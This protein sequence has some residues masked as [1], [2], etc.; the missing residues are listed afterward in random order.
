MK[1]VAIVQ[2]VTS[3]YRES[4]YRLLCEQDEDFTVVLYSDRINPES[5]IK[6]IDP[7]KASLPV[8][9]GGLRWR[10][11]KS[12]CLFGN[13]IWQK[14]VVKLGISKEFDVI[15]YS[16]SAYFL[17]TWISCFLA[18]M[19]GKRTL[20]WCHGF[21]RE[22]EGLKGWI[23]KIFYRLLADGVLL[24]HNRAKRIMIN[25]GFDADSLYVIYNSLDYDTQCKIKDEISHEEI[26]SRRQKMFNRPDLPLWLFIGR[27]NRSKKLEMILDAAKILKDRGC[28]CNILIIGDGPEKNNLK[29]L[30]KKQELD[31]NVFL[32]G[33]TYDEKELSYLISMSDICVSP[34]E[35]GLTCM[36]ALGY[37][38]PVITHDDP[39][40]QGPEYEAIKPGYNGAFFKKGDIEDLA[41]TI[42]RWLSENKDREMIAK[43]CYEVIDQY[44]NPHYQL[45]VI[46]AAILQLLPSQVD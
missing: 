21:L 6:T 5:S 39:D 38:T 28:D 33:A 24:Y 27:L 23:Q 41:N 7:Q 25:K 1:K 8:E 9:E 37:G 46:R 44:Y 14:G 10:F 42:E 34:G 20:M 29:Q 18:R 26:L 22:E 12:I 13:F 16:G 15:I 35:I 43:R 32:Y 31:D 17:S 4:I 2:Y 45:K 11:V 3:H 40:F 36:H 19:T 30:A